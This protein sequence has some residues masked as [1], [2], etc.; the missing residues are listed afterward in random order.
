MLAIPASAAA[1]GIGGIRDLPVPGW[2]FLVG[3]ATVLVVSFV[4]LGALWTKPKLEPGAGRPLP[5]GLQRV[6]LSPYLRVVVSGLS[7]ALF[8]VVWTAAAFGSE[9][10]SANL[11]PT[12]IYV[13]FWV[14]MVVVT[15]VLGNVWSVLDPWRAAADATA[16]VSGKLGW[17][18][19]PRPY[20]QWL[21][22]WP[23][24]FLLFGFVALELVYSDPSDPR[25]LALAIGVYSAVTWSG[26]FA[27]GRSEWRGNGDGF[28]VYFGL[29]SR[30][31]LFG[32]RERDGRTQLIL[33][34]PLS[35]LARLERRPGAVAFLA[36]MLGSVAFDG[37][38][39]SSW[40]FER[41]Y[42]VETRFSDPESAER[43]VML[44]N[45]SALVLAVLFVATVYTL[46]VKIAEG[47]VGE[48]AAFRGVF[49]GSLIPIA[50]VYALSHYLSLLIIQG[51]FAIPLLSDP[52]G[53][54][55][56]VLGTASFDPD[57]T[58]LKPNTTW[59][60]QVTVLV[61]G[62][63]L[64]LVVAHDRAVA[65]SPTPQIALRTQYAMLSLMVLYTVG[66][67]WLLSLE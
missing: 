42:D 51:Q 4:A 13:W 64:A 67:M 53:Q 44:L 66:G 34:R 20:P 46:S 50:I 25:M 57:L 7:L 1:H 11:A 63:V 47:V 60:A 49:V 36:V 45:L 30:V 48:R 37:V 9:R 10:A 41:I 33:R 56:N 27:Y 6:L 43:A 23:A 17:A 32:S 2:L 39:R 65:L 38:S 8:A 22:V 28:A 40:W 58:L 15:I 35:E 16:W 52:Y 24:V 18:R 21:G 59:Y 31:A 12:F 55:W 54:G 29:I 61:I 19:T 14:G 3:G 5:D 26:M 62:H